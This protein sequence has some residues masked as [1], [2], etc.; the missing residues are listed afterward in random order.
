METK[1][2]S[3][4]VRLYQDYFD[5][6]NN[7]QQLLQHLE[8]QPLY[9][10]ARLKAGSRGS[11][12]SHCETV[13]EPVTPDSRLKVPEAKPSLSTQDITSLFALRTSTPRSNALTPKETPSRPAHLPAK[14]RFR[15]AL[16]QTY[17]PMIGKYYS[18]LTPFKQ[19]LSY[20]SGCDLGKVQREGREMLK[21]S[22][23]RGMLSALGK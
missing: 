12:N 6:R 8:G 22:D 11:V 15:A 2:P 1:R 19:T 9:P 4:H 5:R 21:Y 17:S 13:E 3:I 23:S 18:Q 7:R 20:S 16:Q 10:L 14:S